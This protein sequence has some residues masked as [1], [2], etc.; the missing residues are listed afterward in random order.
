MPAKK[1]IIT[2]ERFGRLTA[3]SSGENYKS[4]GGQL[5]R[6]TI[7]ACECGTVLTVK[8]NGLR[9]GNTKSCGC[10]KK[11]RTSAVM[12]KHGGSRR[13]STGKR[14]VEYNTWISIIKR[15]ENKAARN[16]ADYGGR[17]I[18]VCERWRQSYD[19]FIA[20]M[21]PRPSEK[22]SIDRFPDKN[23][24]YEPDNCRWAT[25]TEQGRNKRNNN[26]LTVDG[27]TRCVTEWA[28]IKG[29]KPH[30]IYS[31]KRLGWTDREAVLGR[32]VN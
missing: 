10:F 7:C 9:T 5:H 3:V 28:S 16:Y 19:N 31:R 4:P 20:D 14:S 1:D 22:H 6:T 17:G 23:G 25:S 24:N 15:T 8:N 18:A 11:D 32:I 27:E 26:L 2:G 21:G 29:L 12:T 30:V 13:D